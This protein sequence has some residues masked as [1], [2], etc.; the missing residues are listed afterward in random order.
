PELLFCDNETNNKALFGSENTAPFTKDGINNF[1]VNDEKGAV[2]TN[3]FGTKAAAHYSFELQPGESKTISARLYNRDEHGVN[4]KPFAD[5]GKVFTK[6]VA[7]ADAFYSRVVPQKLSDD[8][9]NVQRQAFAGML[10]SKQYYHYVVHTWLDGDPAFPPP[11]KERLSGRNSNWR[12]LY[13]SDVISMPDKW[14]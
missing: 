13:N 14:E 9:K 4:K 3:G 12:H 8:A 7:E 10:W 6:R 5:L 11:P 2:N 1:V